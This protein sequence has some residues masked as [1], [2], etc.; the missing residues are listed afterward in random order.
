MNN[1][2]CEYSYLWAPISA[3]IIICFDIIVHSLKK[4]PFVIRRVIFLEVHK[5]QK[6]WWTWIPFGSMQSRSCSEEKYK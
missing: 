6:Q 3:L 2:A 4:K 5:T 1:F